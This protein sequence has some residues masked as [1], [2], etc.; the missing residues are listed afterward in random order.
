[1]END[2][3]SALKKRDLLY[4]L[5]RVEYRP[6]DYK[7][8]DK[9][10]LLFDEIAFKPN[11]KILIYGDY[12]PDG[13][14]FTLITQNF[15][16]SLMCSNVTIFPY[17][18]R[19]HELDRGAVRMCIQGNYDYFIIGDTASNAISALNEI[20]SNGTKIIVID[21]HVTSYN[22]EDY[23]SN[24]AIINSQIENALI[25]K[26]QYAYSAAALAYSIYDLYAGE[27]YI[28]FDISNACYALV[29]LYS[30][31]MDMSNR[32]NRAIYYRACSVERESLPNYILHFL[33]EFQTFGARFIGFW[34]A[35]R[36]NSLFRS[37]NFDL[38][39][40]YFFDAELN[41]IERAKCIEEINNIYKNDREFTNL[42]S[43]LVDV[44]ELEHFVYANLDS[45]VEKNEY[46]NR[47][48]YNYTGLVAN[49][50]SQ[51]Y[52]K[53]AVVIC[54]HNDHYKGS[55]RDLYGRH[56]LE[57]F[58]KMG[59]AEG[60][61]SAFGIQIRFLDLREYR[62][63]LDLIDKKYSIDSIP[64]EPIIIQH[65]YAEP[66]STLLND[67][68]LYNEFSGS[69]IPVTYIYKQL[70]GAMKE[71]KNAYYYKY[72]WGDFFVQSEH[73]LDFATKMI[74][75]PIHSGRI[76]LLYQG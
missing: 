36:I 1:M 73:K 50:L 7:G 65:E 11:S 52:N 54:T 58:K 67:I 46:L 38:V 43:D 24:V 44:E 31:C 69:A 51:R 19:T 35:P 12:D 48:A 59:Y 5:E 63:R 10:R 49:K 62:N 33:N 55:V 25:D 39:N 22:Y 8:Y 2:F 28:E 75:K 40:K 6:G 76:K 32:Y 30:D 21:H 56:Y 70:V 64:N 14:M 29:S 23:N 72:D 20:A 9:M 61:N 66:D 57:L 3:Y 74:I 17:W 13:L 71:S 41:A 4:V 26:Q 34:Y 60:H 47:K 42:L 27:H 16:D 37:E 53:T 45:A 18:K 15:L 68:A